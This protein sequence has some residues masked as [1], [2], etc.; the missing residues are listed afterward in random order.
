MQ[1][2]TSL[3]TNQTKPT[4]KNKIKT[5]LRTPNLLVE[6]EKKKESPPLPPFVPTKLS[7]LRAI[8]SLSLFM[9]IVLPSFKYQYPKSYLTHTNPMPPC[10]KN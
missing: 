5:K 4:P 2:S 3:T 8:A 7:K 1:T 9:Y 10:G 6:K